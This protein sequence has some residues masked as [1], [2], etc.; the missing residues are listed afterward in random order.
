MPRWFDS[1]AEQL[2][3][4]LASGHLSNDEFNDEMR[5]LQQELNEAADEEAD[6]ARNDYLG[7]W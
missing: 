3:E 6:R 5:L 2:E 1:A 7:E 4:E